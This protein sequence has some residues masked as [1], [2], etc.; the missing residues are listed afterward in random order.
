MGSHDFKFEE[1]KAK[2][3][4]AKLAASRYGDQ[5]GATLYEILIELDINP[6]IAMRED[7][8]TLSH[9]GI[10]FPIWISSVRTI[11]PKALRNASNCQEIRSIVNSVLYCFSHHHHDVIE[12]KEPKKCTGSDALKVFSILKE[13]NKAQS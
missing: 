8:I 4:I 3:E 2:L 9:D 7:R 11:N 13:L 5:A 6:L 12:A 10:C 1:L